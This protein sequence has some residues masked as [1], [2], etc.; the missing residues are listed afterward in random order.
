MA[1]LFGTKESFGAVQ[2]EYDADQAD[3]IN[4]SPV[5]DGNTVEDPMMND[6]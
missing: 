6:D 1:A 5:N 3:S 4:A 2:R